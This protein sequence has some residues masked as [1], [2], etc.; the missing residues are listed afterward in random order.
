MTFCNECFKLLPLKENRYVIL[1]ERRQILQVSSWSH[2]SVHFIVGKFEDV[3]WAFLKYDHL[4]PKNILELEI[5]A[6]M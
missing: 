2:S 4:H 3:N 6:R 5:D 1:N